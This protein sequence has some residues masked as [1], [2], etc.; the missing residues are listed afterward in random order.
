RPLDQTASTEFSLTRFLTPFLAAQEGWV[1]FCD[2]DFLYTV[3]VHEVLAGLDP[4]KAV[5]VVQH[6]YTPSFGVKMDGQRQTSYPRKNW[7]SFMVLNCDHPDVVA[8]SPAVVNTAP[9]AYLHRFEWIA[10]DSDIGALELDWNFLE[11]EYP[12]PASTPRVIHFTNGGPWFDQ[13]ANVDYAN[14]WRAE[15]KLYEVTISEPSPA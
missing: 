9:P 1:I 6:D 7:S 5:Y 8:L 14:L 11:G 10:D 2:C 13:W 4:S 12:R 3:D 15:R